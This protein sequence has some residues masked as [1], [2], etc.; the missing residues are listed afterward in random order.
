MYIKV[1]LHLFHV[2][3]Y[4]YI[5]VRIRPLQ[6]VLLFLV[7]RPHASG[8]FQIFSILSSLHSAYIA[9][10]RTFILT[11]KDQRSLTCIGGCDA[12]VA[13]ARMVL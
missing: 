2:H 11:T 12:D 8:N 4:N 10:A 13:P 1:D 6:A 5:I 9:H 7:P 3:Y